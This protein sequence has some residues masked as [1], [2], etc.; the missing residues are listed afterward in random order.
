MSCENSAPPNASRLSTIAARTPGASQFPQLLSLGNRSIAIDYFVRIILLYPY[1][2][3]STNISCW[4]FGSTSPAAA[5]RSARCARAE[6][7]PASGLQESTDYER[8]V[9]AALSSMA[10]HS[11]LSQKREGMLVETVA[12]WLATMREI[13]G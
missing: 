10:Y 7:T 12:P 4:V 3:C 11:R 8:G 9:P 1:R 5:M 13:Y 6:R 2:L